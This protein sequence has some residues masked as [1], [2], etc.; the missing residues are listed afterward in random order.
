[1]NLTMQRLKLFNKVTSTEISMGNFKIIRYKTERKCRSIFYCMI[2]IFIALQSCIGQHDCS[3]T[4]TWKIKKGRL[5]EKYEGTAPYEFNYVT[6]QNDSIELASG[7]FYNTLGANDDYPN[8][9]Y[10]FVYYGNKEIYSKKGNI[11]NIFSRP[12]NQWTSF[13]MECI[14]KNQ[15]RLFN[16]ANRD[17]VEM[18]KSDKLLGNNQCKIKWIKVRVHKGTLDL[19][20]VGY[21]VAFFENDLMVYEEQDSATEFFT[22]KNFQLPKGSFENICKGFRYVTFDSLKSVY[23]ATTSDYKMAE[24]EIE[25]TDGKNIK[26]VIQDIAAG[27]AP[28]ELRLA[29]VPVLYLHQQLVYPKLPAKKFSDK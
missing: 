22:R 14:G 26:S 8:G 21:K 28:T 4:G 20:N 15:I 6:F 19:F 9:R 3:V 18:E 27:E 13:E 10:P 1:M 2:F 16:K 11:L 17:T 25:M 5:N 24:V 23:P 29:L 7:F 12:Y